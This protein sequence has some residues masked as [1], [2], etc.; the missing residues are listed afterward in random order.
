MFKRLAVIAAVASTA[1]LAVVPASIAGGGNSGNAVAG[2]R[3]VQAGVKFLIQNNLLRAAALQQID[4]ST[5]D[6][7]PGGAGLINTDLPNPSYLP[8]GT[9]IRLHFTN[10]EL[11]DWCA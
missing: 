7:G 2:A 9:V 10:P 6:S 1:A 5:L 11:F 8:L 4:Y 3:C